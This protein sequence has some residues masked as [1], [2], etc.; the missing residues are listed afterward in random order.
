MT[1]ST[2]KT[3]ELDSYGVWVKSPGQNAD[4]KNA[5]DDFNID[6]D[7]PDFSEID[8]GSNISEAENASAGKEV[9]SDDFNFSDAVSPEAPS[10]SVNT[11]QNDTT[12]T[13]AELTNIAEGVSESPASEETK[14]ADTIPDGEVSLDDFMDEGFSEP[15]A[16]SAAAASTPAAH[17]EKTS[18]SPAPA[19]NETESVSLDDFMDS[20]FSAPSQEEK[21]SETAP[22]EDEPLDIDLSFQ[23]SPVQT[24]EIPVEDISA[25]E[26]TPSVQEASP[27]EAKSSDSIDADNFDDMFGNI[28][29][30]NTGSAVSD[31]DKESDSTTIKDVHTEPVS[32]SSSGGDTENV[33]LSDFGIDENAEEAPVTNNVEETKKDTVIDYD[34]SV[35]KDDGVSA[36]PV[37]NE[38]KDTSTASVS[39]AAAAPSAAPAAATSSVNSELLQQ[40]VADL[41]GLKNQISELK[42]D[43]AEIKSRETISE[44]GKK[45][46]G[47]FFS[48]QDEDET[49]SLSGDELD[50]IM[51]TADFTNENKESS[52]I[53]DYEEVT[54]SKKDPEPADE[55]SESVPEPAESA[56][57]NLLGSLD[58]TAEIPES[59]EEEA[60]GGLTMNFDNEKLEEP[61]LDDLNSDTEQ[62]INE[63]LPDEISI[64]KADDI[65]VESSATDFMDS[66]KDSTDDTQKDIADV[67]K[68]VADE[69][70]FTEPV[71]AEE[72]VSD[73]EIKSADSA[74][75]AITDIFQEEPP[76]TA[77]LTPNHIDYLKTDEET[78]AETEPEIQPAE[79][80]VDSEENKPVEK[81]ES[82]KAADTGS[83]PT[84]LKQEI[85][86]VLLYMDQ[87]LENLPEEKILEFAR[88]EQF[89][90]YKKLFSDLG[91]S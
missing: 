28:Q 54:D 20:D 53:S 8:T 61:N 79:E 27:V 83:I 62:T 39:A 72:L 89:S 40:I 91:L 24:E 64:P 38:V 25:Q 74:D 87:L 36:A 59:A 76:I 69:S 63:E 9:T 3:N 70:D 75:E 45:Q 23:D 13:S 7:L 37:V 52:T 21:P 55:L 68:S 49:I 34:L 56:D 11:V 33:D 88:S 30:E 14:T 19:G 5:A 35:S 73:D 77:A 58:G 6:A 80:I 65:L 10:D 90:T 85:K 66:V 47:G 44:N 32:E 46:D 42:N 48:E 4:T 81:T 82:A 51:N 2:D 1:D 31:T 15:P 41:S 57:D 18:E 17:E 26:E 60:S 86:S 50:N 16:S 71:P 22:A 43:F 29:D 78:A 67:S 12:L 84:D